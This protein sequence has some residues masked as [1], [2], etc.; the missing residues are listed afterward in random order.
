MKFIGHDG[1]EYRRVQFKRSRP[2]KTLI[3]IK[4]SGSSSGR[5]R[6]YKKQNEKKKGFTIIYTK[7]IRFTA[8]HLK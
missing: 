8:F 5:L 7:E 2:K 1:E 6:A 3:P 4:A